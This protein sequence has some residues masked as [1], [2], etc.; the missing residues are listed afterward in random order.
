MHESKIRN[1][2]KTL[3]IPIHATGTKFY[4]N[5]IRSEPV[6]NSVQVIEIR[7]PESI[8]ITMQVYFYITN[9]SKNILSTN[10]IRSLVSRAKREHEYAITTH[11]EH[12]EKRDAQHPIATYN[13]Y[14]E[15]Y[16]KL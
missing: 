2:A 5:F 12:S 11:R 1:R 4:G 15:Q 7:L 3:G 6:R 13:Y 16:N 10:G 8:P 14:S 9:I